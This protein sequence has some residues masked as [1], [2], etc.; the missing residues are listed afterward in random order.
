M[1]QYG[2]YDEEPQQEER[3]KA[4]LFRIVAGAIMVAIYLAMAF[5]LVFTTYFSH[6]VPAWVRYS[7]GLVFFV[8]G[9]FRGYRLYAGRK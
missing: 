3:S 1:A 7:M 5:L 9:I 4:S 6:T 8:Y 2:R